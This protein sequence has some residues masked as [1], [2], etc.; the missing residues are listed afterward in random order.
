M[1][2]FRDIRLWAA[3]SFFTATAGLGAR[4]NARASPRGGIPKVAFSRI[5]RFSLFSP[6]SHFPESSESVRRSAVMTVH[7]DAPLLSGRTRLS[8]SCFFR[9]KPGRFP[10]HEPPGSCP[11]P[12]IYGE[13]TR[14]PHGY[15][16]SVNKRA[17]PRLSATGPIAG[18]DR[19][20]NGGQGVVDPP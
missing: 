19:E 9:N 12:T 20:K 10:K 4:K 18:T 11:R 15:S 7:W 14:G 3:C 13:P 5:G 17:L 8:G 16:S 6:H 1:H 2:V